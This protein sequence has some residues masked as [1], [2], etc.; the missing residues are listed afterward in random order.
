VLNLVTGLAPGTQAKMKVRR[1]GE[2][3]DLAIT[4]GR[5]P[6]PQVRPE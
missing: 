5:R 6:K 2:D 1:K 3:M 4:V